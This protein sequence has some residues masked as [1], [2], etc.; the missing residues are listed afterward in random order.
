MISPAAADS[1]VP[2]N[3]DIHLTSTGIN[4]TSAKWLYDGM[5]LGEDGPILNSIHYL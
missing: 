3:T 4:A 2:A 1:V 5:Y